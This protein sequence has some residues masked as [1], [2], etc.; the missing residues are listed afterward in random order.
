MAVSLRN[1]PKIRKFPFPSSKFEKKSSNWRENKQSVENISWWKLSEAFSS[2][3]C[4]TNFGGQIGEFLVNFDWS[5]F[6]IRK[7]IRQIGGRTSNRQHW[8]TG[9]LISEL[10][11]VVPSISRIFRPKAFKIAIWHKIRRIW[12]TGKLISE[13]FLV[14]P[15]IS[16]I[17]RPK[18]S[19]LHFDTK[20]VEF[21]QRGS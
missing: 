1:G 11:L 9:K 20:F 5:K 13:L 7:E 15:S 2:C 18:A 12:P 8:P 4:L 10:F 19:R 21:G 16:R 3:W 6:K 17:F 14:V